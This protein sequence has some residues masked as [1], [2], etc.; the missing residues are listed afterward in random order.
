[1][2]NVLLVCCLL[3][4]VGCQDIDSSGCT[5]SCT[6][7][8]EEDSYVMAHIGN[9]EEGYLWVACE[10]EKNV[11]LSETAFFIC[12]TKELFVDTNEYYGE[13]LNRWNGEYNW[14]K[15]KYE[16]IKARFEDKYLIGEVWYS[17]DEVLI[18]KDKYASEKADKIKRL[19]EKKNEKTTTKK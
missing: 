8:I 15:F 18:Y 7:P 2:K 14:L 9:K 3:F 5:V 16:D 11:L 17:E 19:K 13:Y 12:E 4:L 6:K 10:K 1:M